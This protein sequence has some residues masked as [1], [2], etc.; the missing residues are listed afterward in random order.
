LN[1]ARREI[2][3]IRD[4]DY[5]YRDVF[6][7]IDR[8]DRRFAFWFK[9]IDELPLP[10]DTT[11]SELRRRRANTAAK[12][13][14]HALRDIRVYLPIVGVI[15]RSAAVR[16]AFE[17]YGPL[18][19]LAKLLL[20]GPQPEDNG[21]PNVGTDPV[22][23]ILS[24]GWDYTPLTFRP[25]P[26]I[27]D[28]III[29]LPAC[30]TANPLLV[31]LAG[32]EL[33]HAVWVHEKLGKE[34]SDESSRAFA[35]YIQKH[36]K[37][38]PHGERIKGKT[39]TQARET[40][41]SDNDLSIPYGEAMRHITRQIEELF[42]DFIGLYLFGESFL[43]AFAY[44]LSPDFPG[45]RSPS[46]PTVLSRV[47]QLL[48]VR[49]R[50]AKEWKDTD[51]TL[52]KNFL[53]HFRVLPATDRSIHTDS[54]SNALGALW[55]T[56]VDAVAISLVPRLVEKIVE[57]SKRPSWVKLRQFSKNERNRIRNSFFRWAVPAAGAGSLTNIM[58]AAWDVQ[59][60][61]DFWKALP[62]LRRIQE[63]DE[64]K[65]QEMR[66]TARLETLF[67]L[68]LKNI[69][70]LEYEEIIRQPLVDA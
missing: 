5:A 64:K 10:A 56:A 49:E 65:A 22:R 58:N 25:I 53:G 17:I 28:F 52:P 29:V 33:G 7:A 68:V 40:L 45:K 24:N 43:H 8:I 44:F 70:V 9:E 12:F 38:F 47:E 48:R 66:E 57:F 32:H 18:R 6:L 41:E 62:A 54:K 30:E 31:P 13:C 19:K 67:E 23:L 26:L 21:V 59:L 11:V 69:E 15:A 3:A 27:Q 35:S 60:A 16:N 55:Q 50:Y 42:C 1:A 63:K 51:Y 20:E 36:H 37:H 2:D 34:L 46:Y 61:P 4:H 14:H 39:I